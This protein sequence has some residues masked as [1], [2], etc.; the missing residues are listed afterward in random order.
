MTSG[1]VFHSV[2]KGNSAPKNGNA[3][4]WQQKN[5][6]PAKKMATPPRFELKLTGPKPVVLPLHHG[7]AFEFIVN[8]YKIIPKS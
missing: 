1:A 8:S 7:V 4:K 5:G 3:K 2:Q 6:N